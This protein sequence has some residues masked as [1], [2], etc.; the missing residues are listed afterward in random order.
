MRKL[1]CCLLLMPFLLFAQK[2]KVKTVIDK[3]T[4]AKTKT[5][6]EPT[7]VKT[8]ANT[9]VSINLILSDGVPTLIFRSN[10]PDFGCTL[11][12]H[13]VKI[14]FDDDLSYSAYNTSKRCNSIALIPMDDHGPIMNK[15]LYDKLQTNFI[16]AVRIE[17]DKT[18]FDFDL[19][20]TDAIR[21]QSAAAELF[22][23]N[24]KGFGIPPDSTKTIPKRAA[25]PSIQKP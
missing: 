4:G 5:L 19:P 9:Y 7:L 16:K 1:L 2:T 6:I 25:L 11:E 17:N 22:G 24:Y 15:A 20:K 3:F 23:G 8:G 10:D 12:N 18:F 13:I 14:L 21:F